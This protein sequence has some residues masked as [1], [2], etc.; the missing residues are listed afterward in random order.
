LV[1]ILQPGIVSLGALRILGAKLFD[2]RKRSLGPDRDGDSD[3]GDC[4]VDAE[5]HQQEKVILHASSPSHGPD[6]V[7]YIIN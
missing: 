5:E 6:N 4:D 1:E 7:C 3:D 2:G